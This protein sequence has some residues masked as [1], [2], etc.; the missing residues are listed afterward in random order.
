MIPESL[1]HDDCSNAEHHRIAVNSYKIINTGRTTRHQQQLQSPQKSRDNE[2]Q[3][4]VSTHRPRCPCQTRQAT[5]TCLNSTLSK[6][7]PHVQQ[8]ISEL[9]HQILHFAKFCFRKTNP[10]LFQW[11]LPFYSSRGNMLHPRYSTYTS[12]HTAKQIPTPIHGPH[13]RYGHIHI[14]YIIHYTYT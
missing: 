4:P 12:K 9:N 7:R 10:F 2:Y 3:R 6:T 13:L 14:P 11:K 5:H 8:I 1:H